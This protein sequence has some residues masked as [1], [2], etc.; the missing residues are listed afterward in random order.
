MTTTPNA[1]APL[2]LADFQ[3]PHVT[4]LTDMR[5]HRNQGFL[6]YIYSNCEIV[7]NGD[8]FN[9]F[10]YGPEGQRRRFASNL[11][12]ARAISLVNEMLDAE[13]DIEFTLYSIVAADKVTA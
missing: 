5:A 13:A 8:G 10:G 11:T 7:P 12:E 6:C 9:V 3:A 4:S 1:L 2:T